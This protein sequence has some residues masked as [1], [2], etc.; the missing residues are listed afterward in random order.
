[1][2]EQGIVLDWRPLGDNG[3][4][5]LTARMGD[6][7]LAV[8]KLDLLKP[9]K[10]DDFATRLVKDRPGIDRDAIDGELLRIA[11]ALAAKPAAASADTPDE[12]DG[13]R[14][15]RPELFHTA[16]V[17]GIA[18]P[19]VR[20]IGGEAVGRWMLC[21]R[22]VD[23]KR[24][25][26]PLEN[27]LDLSDGALWFH[28]VSG[29]PAATQSPGWSAAGRRGW[30]G[31]L[32]AP[33]P[34]DLFRRVCE[35][36]A[37]YV[38]FSADCAPG[39]IAT[40]SLWCVFTYVYPAWSAV[41]YLAIGGP[42]GSGKTTL[43]RVLA[44]LAFRPLE[45]SNMTA[46]CL[47]RALHDCGGVLVLDEAERLRDSAPEAGELR[48]I[49]LSGYKRGSPAMRL[50]KVGDGFRRVGFDVFG[51]KAIGSIAALPEA[52]AD[53]CVRLTMFRAGP[54]SPKPRR[55]LDDDA[56]TW[57]RLRDDLHALALEHGPTWLG[58]A[59]RA[60]AAPATI[61]G[62]D[63]ELWQPLLALAAWLEERGAQGLH[64]LACEFAERSIELGRDDAVPE[65]D[66]LLLRILA[67]RVADGLHGTL[68]AGDVLRKAQEA[69]PAT[70]G[71]WSARGVGNAIGRYGLRTRKG[72]GSAGRTYAG[73]T[74]AD[75]RRIEAGYGFDL[76][77]PAEQVP[78]VPRCTAST[79]AGA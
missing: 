53:R 46:P 42:K 16:E 63:Y 3:T 59:G 61:G 17:S 50:E 54:V 5:T 36:L 52:L 47:F 77:L 18:V 41:P 40:A 27:T 33:D 73:V 14:L 31:G 19:S 7:V 29:E 35:R 25:R 72:H 38:E 43:L 20:M 32:P 1:M 10:R 34:C 22:W 37:W 15:V 76:S 39:A 13:G 65:A 75:L 23:G 21:L 30:L 64:R 26:K 79:A 8:E 58:L 12:V 49:L 68:R 78:L 66:E 24:E 62:R 28:P 55:R 71:K 60:D 4:A 48:S 9:A 69:D 2:S 45:S 44:R 11:G 70:F 6:E 56:G 57:E 67:E 74:L 51:P